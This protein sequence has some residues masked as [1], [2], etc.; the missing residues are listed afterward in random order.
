MS[1][2]SGREVWAVIPARGGSKG[3]PGKNLRLLDGRPLIAHAIETAR[4]AEEVTRII[5]STEDPDIASVAR[6]FGAEVPFLRPE[7]LAGD[8]ANLRDAVN[9]TVDRLAGE[10]APDAVVILY[11]THPF[12]KAGQVDEA[13][14]RL[15]TQ[16]QVTSAIPV[17]VDYSRVPHVRHVSKGNPVSL[18]LPTGAFT[19]MRYLPPGFRPHENV[20]QF[21]KLVR[22][23]FSPTFRGAGGLLVTDDPG[24]RIDLDAP[25]DFVQ[26]EEFILTGDSPSP[27]CVRLSACVLGLDLLTRERRA[28]SGEAEFPLTEKSGIA[29]AQVFNGEGR[30]LRPWGY[31]DIETGPL[32]GS[33]DGRIQK[34]IFEVD[35]PPEAVEV[36]FH[37]ARQKAGSFHELALPFA[38]PPFWTW[39]PS[40]GIRKNL[41]TGEEIHGRQQE[42]RIFEAVA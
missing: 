14:R 3:V 21:R 30:V 24:S 12:R 32:F 19:S 17:S 28:V 36:A 1:W 41:L 38:F 34:G 35:L 31:H 42:P 10:G 23:R 6:E 4:A 9:Y 13:V 37:V 5:V 39:D 40:T 29:F 7:E 8:R 15:E 16:F 26:A 33:G 25:E 22:E 2:N 27:R 18:F 20:D 11:P